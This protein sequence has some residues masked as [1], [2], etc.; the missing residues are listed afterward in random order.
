[1]SD[2]LANLSTFIRLLFFGS[3]LLVTPNEVDLGP[4]WM[5]INLNEPLR[6]VTTGAFLE[7]DIGKEIDSHLDLMAKRKLAHERFPE[8]CGIAKLVSTEGREVFLTS[9]GISVARTETFLELHTKEGV[10][11]DLRFKTLLVK[12][13]CP[14][15]ATRL[16]WQNSVW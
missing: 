8:G 13:N 9:Y 3:R 1:L 14:I 5:T 15:N 6:A 16:Y 4:A 7:V 2:F 10:P 12:F 11:T